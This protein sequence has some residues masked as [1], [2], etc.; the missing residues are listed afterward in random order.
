MTSEE[1]LGAMNAAVAAFDHGLGAWPSCDAKVRMQHVLRFVRA[2]KTRREEVVKG[3]MWEIG[4]SRKDAEKEFDRTVLYIEETVKLLKKIER[5][6]R[7]TIV[8]EGFLAEIR[9]MPL[10]VALC[11]GPFNYPLNETFTTL[12]PA[13][14]MGNTIIFKPGRF[15]VLFL[16]PFLEM[17]RDCFPAGV[18]NVIYGEG[19][20]IISPIMASGLLDVFVFIGSHKTANIIKKQH[21][22]PHRLTSVLGLD[23]KNPAILLPDADLA[24]AI[25]DC[26]TGALSF[27]GQRC[28]ALKIFFVHRSILDKFLEMFN[29]AL[30]KMQPGL[31]WTAGVAFTSLPETGKT[32][33]LSTLVSDAL[34]NGAT[35]QNPLG[36]ETEGAFFYPTVLSPVNEKMRIYHE[37]QFGPVIPV[38]PFDD[39][40]MPVNYVLNSQYGQQA[41]IFGT[42]PATIGR[43]I[44]RLSNQLGR[45]NINAQCQRGPDVFPFAGRKDS[46]ERVLSIRDAL[47]VFSFPTILTMRD[48]EVNR[49]LLEEMR[50]GKLSEFV[51]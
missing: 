29:A 9:R 15:G 22:N 33:Y 7:K 21:P 39:P 35:I 8:S 27:N 47:E 38:V 34:A 26:V 40:E 45:I 36:G 6:S 49:K 42:N 46:A 19:P 20:T 30:A 13:I 28:T 50:V 44:D 3:L 17:F 2:M 24:T 12:L 51:V 37:E 32:A 10:G 18:V 14:L 16:R 1:S 5:K 4:K 31:P 41:S 25:P 11:M 43:Y 23:A 48:S